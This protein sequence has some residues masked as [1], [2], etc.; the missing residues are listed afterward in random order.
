MNNNLFKKVPL[1]F[2][3]IA[4]SAAAFAGMD[5]DSRVSQ[6]ETQMK[7]VRIETEQESFGA[8][9]ASARPESDLTGFYIGAG[10]VY[11]QAKAGG[12]DYAYTDNDSANTFPIYG[13]MQDIDY[14]WGW[15]L[16]IMAGY[17]MPHDG[18]DVRLNYHYY[19]QSSN[20][21]VAA[22]LNGVIVPLRAASTIVDGTE[23]SFDQ[24]TSASSDYSLNMNLLDLQ[25]GRDFFVSKMLTLRP[26][27]GLSS[28]WI[29]QKQNTQYSGGSQLD[30]N[31]VYVND[32]SKFWGMGPEVGVNTQWYLGE[33]FSI[34]GDVN[35]SLLYGRF[36]VNHRENYSQNVNHVISIN[37]D[38]HRVVPTAQ[39]IIG[40]SYD[41]YVDNS[42]HHF[43]I[44]IGYNVE[45]FFFQ[46]QMLKIDYEADTT[47]HFERA[48]ENLGIHGLT[49]DASWS[50]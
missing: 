11:Q 28:Q 45:Y 27:F 39:G 31:S 23:G 30:V 8:N 41:T 4:A 46:N 10:F 40:L 22:G 14:K 38:V 37:G 7:Q 3:A 29:S 12:T 16:N 9:T 47:V 1:A 25:L 26:F 44:R 49:V 24:C 17:N 50:F 6:L 43:G 32:T 42:T 2:A 19:D 5:M 36:D 15:G 20:G 34:F 13:S 35:G 18:M 21:K 48:N 33:G